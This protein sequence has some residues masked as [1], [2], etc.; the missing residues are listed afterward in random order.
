MLWH[1]D[2]HCHILLSINVVYKDDP[3]VF[4]PI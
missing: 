2:R 3:G 1:I 4:R